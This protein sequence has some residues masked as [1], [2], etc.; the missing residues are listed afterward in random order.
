MRQLPRLRLGDLF[1]LRDLGRHEVKGFAERINAWAVEG[2]LASE[3]RFEAAHAARLTS[4]VGRE[5][6]IALLLDRKNLV[7]QGE[8]QIVLISGEPGIGKSRIAAALNARIASEPHT[9]LRFQC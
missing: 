8:G 9:R 2:L 3:S 1:K 7:W 4:F 5:S 6:E